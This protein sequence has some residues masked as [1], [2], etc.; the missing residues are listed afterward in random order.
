VENRKEMNLISVYSHADFDKRMYAISQLL[1]R[2][3]HLF[4]KKF[5]CL[6]VS[7]KTVDDYQTI[8]QAL[9]KHSFEIDSLR[10]DCMLMSKDLLAFLKTT[11]S[12][13]GT[14]V[15]TKYYTPYLVIKIG[16][17]GTIVD[18]IEIVEF[19]K[20]IQEKSFLQKFLDLFK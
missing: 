11:Y 2:D 9:I 7:I 6:H 12:A 3:I 1:V 10:D 19:I 4:D 20:K 8:E 15:I 14:Y 16:S 18:T 13:E 17:P 5:D